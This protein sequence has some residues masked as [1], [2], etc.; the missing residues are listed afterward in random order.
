MHV[1]FKLDQFLAFRTILEFVL[2]EIYF[3]PIMDILKESEDFKQSK[4]LSHQY[5]ISYYVNLVTIS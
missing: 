5:T 1:R 2:L 4:N 3:T